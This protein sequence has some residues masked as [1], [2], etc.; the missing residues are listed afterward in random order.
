MD[1]VESPIKNTSPPSAP[2]TPAHKRI[3]NK[4]GSVMYPH[5]HP[6][7]PVHG[8]ASEEEMEKRR[9]FACCRQVMDILEKHDYKL[10]KT[11]NHVDEDA[12]D[13]HVR[14]NHT[15]K[16]LASVL[17]DFGAK[18]DEEGV[19]E[20]FGG[21]NSITF[22]KMSSTANDVVYPGSDNGH[23]SEFF[24]TLKREGKKIGNGP[25]AKHGKFRSNF[26]SHDMTPS[27]RTEISYVEKH[28]AGGAAGDEHFGGAKGGSN[29]G[30][31]GNVN[32]SAS[33][34]DVN[35]DNV[36]ASSKSLDS[37]KH[38]TDKTVSVAPKL[39]LGGGRKA[40]G[41]MSSKVT[42]DTMRELVRDSSNEPTN[43]GGAG[44]NNGKQKEYTS[45]NAPFA[46][47]I[48]TPPNGAVFA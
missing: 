39:G 25:G 22:S 5:Q 15:Y 27:G 43:R 3:F 19:K 16:E 45:I 17:R 8:K 48:N 21:G 40:R 47:A 7:P 1:S 46:N 31:H 37:M 13:I 4:E 42:F 14:S 34:Y 41:I 2:V 28:A 29:V 6:S 44:I 26:L 35:N 12:K 30:S 23:G 38:W 9:K 10:K 18:V 24:K 33:K 20:A 36:D 32:D 11:F